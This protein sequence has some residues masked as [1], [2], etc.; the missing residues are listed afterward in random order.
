M[1]IQPRVFG[2]GKSPG[3]L[4]GEAMQ[5][6]QKHIATLL[7]TCAILMAPVSLVKSAATAL[8]L[9]P[10]VA[11][12]VSAKNAER[13]SQRTAEQFQRQLE[14]AQRDPKKWQE[15][16]REQQKQMEELSKAWATTGTAAV[17]ALM[18][19]VLGL[20][21][22][23]LGVALMYGVAVPLTTGALTII[24]ADRATGG[25]AGVGQAFGLLFRRLGKL[26]SAWI[27]AFLL[28]V[29]GLFCLVIPGLVLGFLF[30]FVT[31]VVLLENVGGMAALKRSVALVKAN[32]GQ[33]FVMG[34]IFAAIRILSRITAHL[35]IP[36]SALFLG[37][38]VEDALLIVLMPVPIM[39][40]VL[41]YLDIRRQADGLDEQGLRA[42]IDG[43]RR[44]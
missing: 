32:V 37:S 10:T 41:L 26:L 29:L 7:L 23:V 42:G 1:A 13:L 3:T 6:Y 9:A 20:V 43:L 44:A 27:P 11:V 18:V 22:L 19:F 30:V 28:V 36:S 8:I 33:V 38:L 40:T 25:N 2:A 21:A 5:L 31:P 12:D 24:V 16:S 15:T 39:G 4:L 34:L 14:L 35:F 17:G